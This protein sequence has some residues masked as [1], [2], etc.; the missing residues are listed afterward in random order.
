MKLLGKIDLGKINGK[1]RPDKRSKEEK[2]ALRQEKAEEE[3]QYNRNMA[4]ARLR[5]EID[6][7]ETQIAA[8]EQKITELN[9]RLESGKAENEA[10]EKERS[11]TA[12]QLEYL[13]RKAAV[14]EKYK[15]SAIG[16]DKRQKELRFNGIRP[17]KMDVVHFHVAATTKDAEMDGVALAM[18]ENHYYL[19]VD[20]YDHTDHEDN[21]T[22][23]MDENPDGTFDGIWPKNVVL[24]EASKFEERYMRKLTDQYADDIDKAEAF[25]VNAAIKEYQDTEELK[26]HL[27]E[28]N[29]QMADYDDDQVSLAEACGVLNVLRSDLSKKEQEMKPLEQQT[30]EVDTEDT[31][32]EETAEEEACASQFRCEDTTP[33]AG[34]HF[35][36]EADTELERRCPHLPYLRGKRYMA[37]MD[38]PAIDTDMLPWLRYRLMANVARQMYILQQSHAITY[39]LS[40]D[41]YEE[42]RSRSPHYKGMT[43]EDVVSDGDRA[44]GIIVYPSQGH[45]DTV[46]FTIKRTAQLSILIAYIREGRLMFYESWSVQEILGHPRTD[47]YLCKSLRQ[48][49]TE[50]NRL[51]AWLRNFI[52]AF[53]AMEHDMERTVSHLVEEGAG[54]T[55]ETDIRIEDE[56]DATEDKD[57]AIRNATWY[58]DIT[59]NRQIPVR[60]YISHRWCGSG[61][62]KY[63]RE[64]WVRPHERNGY[65]RTAT[66][67]K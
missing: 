16:N 41:Y 11:E 20:M 48:S 31:T 42:L 3:K 43:V 21:I 49:G 30:T 24:R 32:Q 36:I 62:D 27:N 64:V 60:G 53:L 35:T 65:H 67:K 52:V 47:T 15:P 45:E 7:L 10:R 8:T 18:D 9:A 29:K 46:L 14:R 39:I 66:V 23:C 34:I 2:E 5:K 51:F 4:A 12:M 54:D 50:A 40:E 63:I 25:I 28:L 26:A 57:V 61:K 58:T 33:P 22:T 38:W 56:V 44:D 1:L 6:E 55:E 13:Q 37:T 59:V 19:A 17:R